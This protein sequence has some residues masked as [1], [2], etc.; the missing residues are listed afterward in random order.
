M[1]RLHENVFGR[2]AL[3]AAAC[4]LGA[5]APAAPAPARADGPAV[6]TARYDEK[7]GRVEVAEGGVAVLR[8]NFATVPVPAR[9]KGRQY[10]EA[11]GDYI[12]PLYGPA[13][14]VITADYP[15]DHPHHRGV[16][17]AWP[18]VYYKGGRKDLHALQGVF[19]RPSRLVRAEG[20]P[21]G[22]TIEAES[23]W[24][25]LDTEEIVKER[26]ILRAGGRDKDG[27]RSID[28]EFRFTALADGVSV[29]RRGQSA[30]GGLNLRS[31]LH[32][33]QKI[34]HHTDPAGAKPRRN[35]GQISGVPKGGTETVA[36]ATL[37][38]AAN[39]EY[40]GE[41]IQFPAIAWLQPTF[42]RKGRKFALS[43]DKPLVLRYRLWVRRNPATDE[44]LAE[45]WKAYNQAAGAAR[46]A[47]KDKPAK[48]EERR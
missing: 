42:P 21:A 46:K 45:A 26:A 31:V 11:R 47:A 14:E 43:K 3:A 29:A 18:E 38:H 37:E 30:Y 39:P 19:A 28:L 6:M 2:R 1:T 24:K 12:H 5:A 9:V 33:G 36:I 27:G 41:W 40:P 48:G 35:W 10:A 25:W 4:L 15:D 8:Y 23:T 7:L 16:Y 34:S 13:G 20:G 22:A 32:G 44:Q 17:W